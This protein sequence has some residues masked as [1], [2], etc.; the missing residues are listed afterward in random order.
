MEVVKLWLLNVD[1]QH[2][3]CNFYR[4]AH[5]HSLAY[6]VQLFVQRAHLRSVGHLINLVVQLLGCTRNFVSETDNF[7][8]R[9]ARALRVAF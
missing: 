2:I 9:A 4:R 1:C 7:L 6:H 8:W 3:D 5:M